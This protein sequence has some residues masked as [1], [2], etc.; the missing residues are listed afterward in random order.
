MIENYD[1]LSLN[2]YNYKQPFTGSF[3][4]MRYRLEKQQDENGMAFFRA[5]IWPEPF[6]YEL[7]D[8]EKIIRKDFEFSEE[9]KLQVVS[10]LNEMHEQMDWKEGF[11]ASGLK[12]LRKNSGPLFG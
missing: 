7:T 11:T 4:G 12:A 2:Y 10:W 1:L 6:S 8:P 3:Q 5:E 9:G